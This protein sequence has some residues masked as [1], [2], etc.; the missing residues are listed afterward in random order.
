M[1]PPAARTARSARRASNAARR[2]AR[3]KV[4]LHAAPSQVPGPNSDHVGCLSGGTPGCLTLG[5]P[6]CGP[7]ELRCLLRV[8]DPCEDDC[9][10]AIDLVWVYGP[11]ARC[12]WAPGH[13]CVGGLNDSICC[14]LQCGCESPTTDCYCRNV[15]CKSSGGTCS[16]N[17]QCCDGICESGKCCLPQAIACTSTS[18]CCAG[19]FCDVGVCDTP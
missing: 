14:S 17:I 1:P 9:D 4:P 12:C 19:L 11:N 2:N 3:Q 16:A 5:K 7:V 15:G 6:Q 13:N 8:D 18:Q 10:C